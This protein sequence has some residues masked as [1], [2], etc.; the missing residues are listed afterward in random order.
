[1]SKQNHRT[2]EFDKIN[3]KIIIKIIPPNSSPKFMH[4]CV[5]PSSTP[6]HPPTTT[7]RNTH[8][9]HNYSGFVEELLSLVSGYWARLHDNVSAD[10]L[11]KVAESPPVS[12]NSTQMH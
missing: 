5:P 11:P 6:P 3:I 8:N 4:T 2:F 9:P 12:C 1:M 7:P 10:I